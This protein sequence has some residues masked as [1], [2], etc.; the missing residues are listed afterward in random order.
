VATV[1]LTGASGFIGSELARS[2]DRD[3]HRVVRLTRADAP[4]GRD[5]VGWNAER[6]W[7]D[8]AALHALTPAPEIVIH[9]AGEPIAQRWTPWR[10]Q[11]IR[12]SRVNG[13]AALAKAIG[14]L[15]V[16]P[17]VF[18]SGS[19]IGYYG[20]DRGDEL[21]RE[22]SAPGRDFLA[23]TA[24]AWEAATAAAVRAGIRVVMPRTGVVLGRNGGA[25]ARLLLPFRLG[26]GGRIGSGR[27]WMSWISL[28]DA[29]RALRFV[30][31]TSTVEGAVNLS[32]PAPVRSVEFTRALGRA[33]HRP[34]IV[35]APA[36]ALKLVFGEMA[37]AT[38]LASQRVV[39]E[40]LAGAGFEFRHPR[41]EDALAFELRR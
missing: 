15:T 37:E 11:A 13:T 27:H 41:V 7:I 10:K 8:E 25:M 34:T 35:P 6:G 16:P 2:Y 38:I 17:R 39:P 32:A 20:T 4:Q 33:L 24:M 3:G 40:R 21:L 29:V 18:V 26:V 19:A 36:F 30:A 31:E 9:L 23:Q 28:E 1:L 14:A 22:T 12:D 5:A